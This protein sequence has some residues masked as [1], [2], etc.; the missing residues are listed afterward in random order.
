MSALSAIAEFPERV[1]WLFKTQEV[2]SIGAYEV[3][4]YVMGIPIKIVVD[5]FIPFNE[6]GLIAHACSKDKQE[7]YVSVIEKAFAKLHKW[8]D[9]ICGGSKRIGL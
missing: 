2:N 9:C 1:K 7:F 3:F 4:I 8:Y 6:D 5:D